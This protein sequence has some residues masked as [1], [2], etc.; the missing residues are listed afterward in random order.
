MGRFSYTIPSPGFTPFRPAVLN[1]IMNGHLEVG[2][3]GEALVA[4]I[5]LV[6]SLAGV[7]PLVLEK[8][9]AA[10]ELFAAVRTR[11]RLLATV[12]PQVNDQTLLHRERFACYI[13]NHYSSLN[14]H[15]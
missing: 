10:C 15:E 7:G 14:F 8:L 6:G 13:Q 11:V 9:A 1:Q 3:A 5:A 12:H 2:G 4:L